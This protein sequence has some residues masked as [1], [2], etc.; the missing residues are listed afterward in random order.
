[1]TNAIVIPIKPY[2]ST[3]IYP[4]IRYVKLKTI[5]VIIKILVIA[6]AN[7]RYAINK[8]AI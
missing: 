2:K 4:K 5:S 6:F 8:A 3:H 7:I 1:M